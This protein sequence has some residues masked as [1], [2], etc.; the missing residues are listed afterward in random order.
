MLNF[1]RHGNMAR[2]MIATQLVGLAEVA[3]LLEVTKRTAVTYSQRPDFP[4]PLA[5]LA[6]GPVWNRR[7]VERWARRS[8]PRRGGRPG[9]RR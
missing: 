3:E 7:E 9:P 6:A 4:A 2:E 1:Q 8:K 5:R